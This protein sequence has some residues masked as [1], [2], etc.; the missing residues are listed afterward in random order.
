MGS[1]GAFLVKS[2]S[3][4]TV[5]L[6]E[7]DFAFFCRRSSV[8][9][10]NVLME[11]KGIRNFQVV[12]SPFERLLDITEV[13]KAVEGQEE[14]L[15]APA[16]APGG[17]KAASAGVQVKEEESLSQD[18]SGYAPGTIPAATPTPSDLLKQRPAESDH[19]WRARTFGRFPLEPVHV[20]GPGGHEYVIYYHT[21]HG[22]SDSVLNVSGW[23]TVNRE[24][25]LQMIHGTK[26]YEKN[27]VEVGKHQNPG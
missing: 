26:E 5:D 3:H 20:T 12:G 19:H 11:D 14:N 1:N 10:V 2:P 21:A 13:R 16:E 24:E 22:I 8:E 7:K 9:Y 23:K 17:Q 4:G 15:K 25:I 6:D 18:L 27:F